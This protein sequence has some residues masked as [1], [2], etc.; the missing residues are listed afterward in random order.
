MRA[1]LS[2]GTAVSRRHRRC[3]AAVSWFSLVR[4]SCERTECRWRARARSVRVPAAVLLCVCVPVTRKRR[5]PCRVPAP[6]M[7]ARVGGCTSVYRRA[8]GAAD[9]VMC[10]VPV[11][12][13]AAVTRHDT[14]TH[15]S[16]LTQRFVFVFID[17]IRQ[18]R[19]RAEQ[20][21]ASRYVNSTKTGSHAHGHGQPR[22]GRVEP[23]PGA[24]RTTESRLA[25]SDTQQ[26]TS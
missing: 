9:R 24:S 13:G 1:V 4:L 5:L 3:R 20:R 14:H 11:R 6:S 17:I 10:R 2:C 8:A 22:Q 26:E 12:A 25:T 23:R 21:H 19:D 15:D 7:Y 16:S 18:T